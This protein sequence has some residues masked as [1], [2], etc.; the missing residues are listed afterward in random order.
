MQITVAQ[1]PGVIRKLE[2]RNHLSATNAT[3]Q[4]VAQNGISVTSMDETFEK[5]WQKKDFVIQKNRIQH[6]VGT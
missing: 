3:P 5:L 4:T 6:S 1:E 2:S